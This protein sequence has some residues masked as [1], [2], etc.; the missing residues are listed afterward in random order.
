[1]S[2]EY[3]LFETWYGE[4][5]EAGMFSIGAYLRGNN[6]HERRECFPNHTPNI[7]SIICICGKRVKTRAR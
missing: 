5:D 1:M 6:H 2:C 3:W 7:I 4:E